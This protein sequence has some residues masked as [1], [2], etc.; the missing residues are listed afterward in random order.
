MLSV[1][2]ELLL[3]TIPFE[4]SHLIAGTGWGG[5]FNWHDTINDWTE[6]DDNVRSDSLS[7]RLGEAKISTYKHKLK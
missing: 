3:T 7:V 1:R 2:K 4:E 6:S 5:L